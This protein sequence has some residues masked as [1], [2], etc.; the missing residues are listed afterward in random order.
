MFG[1]TLFPLPPLSAAVC[2]ALSSVPGLSP[3]CVGRMRNELS[4]G[5]VLAVPEER[6]CWLKSFYSSVRREKL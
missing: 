2:F 3:H 4:L 1:K 6:D 5:G